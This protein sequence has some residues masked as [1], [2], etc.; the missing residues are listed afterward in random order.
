MWMIIFLLVDSIMLDTTTPKM[1][2]DTK[3]DKGGTVSGMKNDE[4]GTISGTET[5]VGGMK[6]GMINKILFLIENNETIS[7]TQLSKEIGINRSAIQK[8]IDNLKNKGI[9]YRDC[10]DK[11]GKWVII[12]DNANI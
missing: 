6:S 7:L 2:S 9:I 10:A 1:E 8:H 4:S 5:K 11:G 3:T 12:A